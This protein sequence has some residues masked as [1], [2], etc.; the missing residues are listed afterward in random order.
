MALQVYNT[1][2]NKKEKFVPL[3]EGK[4]KLYLCGPTVYDYLHIGNLRGPITFN[5]MRNWL[6]FIGYDVTF[7]YNYTDVD[8]KIIE[9]ANKEGV[10]AS[11][12]SERYIAAFQEDFARLGLRAH[13]HN[14]KVTDHMS[15]I[16]QFVEDLVAKQ[17]AYVVE[18]E[19]FYSI[20]SFPEYGKLSKNKLEDLNAGQRV[21]VDKRKKNPLDFV[22]WKPA[23]PGEPSWDSPWGPGR[24]GWHI[25]CSAMIK[26]ILGT[27][28]DIHG[29]GIDLIF[30]HHECE[31]AQ[32][33]G[34]TGEQYCRYWIHNNFINLGDEKMSK[35]LGNIIKGREFMD[36]YHPEILKYMFLGSHYR[37][38]QAVTQDKIFQTISALNRIYS[39]LELA[40]KTVDSVS[41]PSQKDAGFEKKLNELNAK[42]TRALN[43]DFNTADFIS[44]IFEGVRAFNALGFGNKAKRNGVHKGASEAFINWMEQYGK[45][46]ALFQEGPSE[47]L[48]RLDEIAIDL[49]QIDKSKVQD[50][51]S[52]R[53]EARNNKDW[54]QADAYRDELNAMGVELL[55]GSDRGWRVIYHD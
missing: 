23:K 5:L 47:F 40:H 19:V 28:I 52:K 25:E 15:Q 7:V 30:P 10:T 11:E 46:S 42:I 34:C 1:L 51:I 20:D 55:D 43:D 48:A 12:I 49:K 4:V 32:G 36:R 35:S 54:Q 50:L 22:L 9:R 13:T 44:Y 17:K 21:E 3:E 53:N 31:I 29:G 18:G 39:A 41:E 38:V 8:D 27:T 6:E 16:I 33:E 45:M 2:S 26:S 24:P 37:S 14:P